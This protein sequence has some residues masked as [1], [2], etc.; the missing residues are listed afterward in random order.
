MRWFVFSSDAPPFVRSKRIRTGTR[1]TLEP[2][3]ERRCLAADLEFSAS[4]CPQLSGAVNELSQFESAEP[5]APYPH[6]TS[7][8]PSESCAENFEESGNK[9]DADR[10]KNIST[11]DLDRDH[12]EEGAADGNE[13]PGVMLGAPP[14]STDL[15]ISKIV[16]NASPILSLS[17]SGPRTDRI[18][19][20]WMV[21]GP[22]DTAS[23]S[24]QVGASGFESTT[25]P[26]AVSS[27]SPAPNIEPI[28]SLTDARPL[29]QSV[30]PLRVLP[31][32][33]LN[34]G[35]INEQF[36]SLPFFEG[37]STL[38]T[39][40]SG[41]GSAVGKLTVPFSLEAFKSVANSPTTKTKYESSRPSIAA[42]T[43]LMPTPK[44][45]DTQQIANVA[46]QKDALS[47]KLISPNVVQ[48]NAKFI[49]I[50]EDVGTAVASTILPKILGEPPEEN[51]AE[52]INPLCFVVLVGLIGFPKPERFRLIRKNGTRD[53]SPTPGPIPVVPLVNELEPWPKTT[54]AKR[55]QDETM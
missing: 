13:P 23:S 6:E 43:A 35:Q 36:T 15:V 18:S 37:A 29:I 25:Q 9:E 8:L 22:A 38:R 33:R 11:D 32:A 16:G 26:E 21:T 47:A 17:P 50:E 19:N 31:D 4:S 2:L 10:I 40:S 53:N 51:P 28:R 45:L 20:E 44:Q 7:S 42:A 24:Q 27:S 1:L 30:E 48:V 39:R 5:A 54:L 46:I 14:L 41:V 52:S 3:E 55:T 34:A 49:P 12:Q